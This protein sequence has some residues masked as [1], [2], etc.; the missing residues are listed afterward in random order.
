MH[1]IQH[2]LPNVPWLLLAT[3]LTLIA[4]GWIGI[5][6]CEALA[7][8]SGRFLRLQMLWTVVSAI[9]MCTAATPSPKTLAR[10]SYFLYAGCLI[11]LIVVFFAPAING[12]HR[13]IRVAGFG[14]Q[15]SEFAKLATVLTL[16]A[17]LAYR[18]T[19]RRWWGLFPPLM[20]VL[21]PMFLILRE[22]DLGTAMLFPPVFVV[23][24]F[25]A[26]ARW[27]DLA[28]LALIGLL[29]A[30]VMWSQM[31]AEQRSRVTSLFDQAGPGER[32]SDDGYQLQQA[33][34]MVALGDRW[35]SAARG[36]YTENAD[37]YHL[38][39]ARSDFIFCVV[40][41]RLGLPGMLG[42]LGLFG[43]LVFRI[44]RIASRTEDP[45]AR[46]TAVGVAAMLGLQAAVATGMNVGLL[47]ITGL[48][49]P[50]LSYGGS[51]LLTQSLGIG[52]VARI[53]MERRLEIG[54]EPFRWEG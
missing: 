9:G 11:L 54:D 26:G 30:P 41:E 3:W 13:W 50:L 35:G 2:K 16:S 34:Q 5:A 42:V 4:I 8:G 52:V 27:K 10:L 37:A 38:P 47:P 28:R 32:A 23:L 22:P 14:F 24:V 51:S 33:K 36:D 15:P 12:A 17:Y 1:R 6:R 31:S 43:L 20:L 39:E 45:F 18:D 40:G 7:G 48:A 25:V 21:L 29:V 19:Y 53:A 49:L 46:L 44:L